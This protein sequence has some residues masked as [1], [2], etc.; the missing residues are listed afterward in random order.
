[1][2]LLSEVDKWSQKYTFFRKL[3]VCSLIILIISVLLF[4]FNLSSVVV[5]MAC[6][7]VSFLSILGVR[8]GLAKMDEFRSL[9]VNTVPMISPE[10]DF[11]ERQLLSE[12][13]EDETAIGELVEV[14]EETKEQVDEVIEEL[15]GI[16]D[17]VIEELQELED[18]V[19]KE[20]KEQADEVIEELQ[21][22]QNEVVE[23]TKEQADEVIEELQ[24]LQNEVVE[25]T[26][27]Q[28]DEVIEGLQELQDEVV[29]ETK[30]QA[31]EVIEELQELEDEVVEETN[32]QADTAIEELKELED[33]MIEES[34]SLTLT[35]EEQIFEVIKVILRQNHCDIEQLSYKTVGTYLTIYVKNRVMIRLKLTGRKQYVLTYLSQS[36]VEV[37]GL[38]FEAPS[39]SEAYTSRIQFTSIAILAQLESHLVKMYQ[40]VTK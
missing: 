10:I 6:L 4:F 2:F 40:R 22:L 28:A 18:E 14:V 15:Q 37:L 20:T 19:V 16:E 7:V 8:M 38:V 26:N 35:L 11:K 9:Y 36:E 23:E 39:K 21:V 1:M 29:E 5:C 17:E 24:V 3:T 31:D 34:E 12:L 13:N 27:E 33:E 25:E 32:G 30:E